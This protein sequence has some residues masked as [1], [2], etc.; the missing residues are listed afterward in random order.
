M[1]N[2]YLLAHA[3]LDSYSLNLIMILLITNSVQ[4]PKEGRQVEAE[5]KTLTGY[6]PHPLLTHNELV[7]G[8]IYK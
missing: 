7:I 8:K 5:Y 3:N 6:F 4:L 2:Q 1:F